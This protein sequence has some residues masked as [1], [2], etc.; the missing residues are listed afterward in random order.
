MKEKEL[1]EYTH[2]R[3]NLT[4]SNGFVLTGVIDAVF[5]DCIKFRTEQK[6]S[7]ISFDGIRVLVE[8]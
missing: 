8:E 3:V 4:L 6:T 7:L 1:K 5:D 2:K